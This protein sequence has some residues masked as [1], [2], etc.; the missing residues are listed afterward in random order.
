MELNDPS[1]CL[2]LGEIYYDE[3]NYEGAVE[4]YKKVWEENMEAAYRLGMIY[5][6]G[7]EGVVSVNYLS[8]KPYFKKAADMGMDDEE[9]WNRFG[10]ILFETEDNEAAAKCFEKAFEFN[11]NPKAAYKTGI[12]YFYM[13]DYENA[14]IWFGK[15]LENGYDGNNDI[16][17]S[18]NE[19]VKDGMVIKPETLEYI[20]P[21]LEN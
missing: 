13:N 5:Y 20:A 11:H 19:W 16:K 17:G 21:W 7:I 15:A 8:A 18:I 6:E 1:S 14:A 12:N 2:N 3:G 10:V 4:C 9:F